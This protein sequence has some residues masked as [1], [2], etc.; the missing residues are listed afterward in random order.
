MAP[1]KRKTEGGTKMSF[2]TDNTLHYATRGLT[3]NRE[4]DIAFLKEQIHE[5]SFDLRITA[6]L[7]R[8][9]KCL[10]VPEAGCAVA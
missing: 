6:A 5:Y 2:M 9:L 4:T 10:T 8:I 3:G 1:S 7:E